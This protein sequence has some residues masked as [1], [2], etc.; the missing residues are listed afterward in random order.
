MTVQGVVNKIRDIIQDA[1]FSDQDILD[2]VNAVVYEVAGVVQ[3]PALATYGTITTGLTYPF[4]AMP[5]DYM[6]DLHHVHSAEF[7]GRIP[8]IPSFN[9]FLKLNPDLTREGSISQ[10]SLYGTNLYYQP[11]AVDTLTLYYWKNP[12]ELTLAGLGAA[13]AVVPV[14]AHVSVL[15]HGGVAE[16]FK[17]I[18]E[19][20][21][22]DQMVSYKK[23]RGLMA[24]GV[25]ILKDL[26][27]PDEGEPTYISDEED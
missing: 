19:G 14:S 11:K 3:L 8:I 1:S 15:V 25:Q 20:L 21:E 12:T 10:V 2:A 5:A 9:R 26:Y 18:E 7:G 13:V 4:V 22:P 16:C 24:S 27:G 17:I 6:R 23:Y